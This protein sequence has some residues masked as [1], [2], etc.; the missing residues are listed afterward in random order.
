MSL[1]CI[2][3][4]DA[5]WD[6]AR[7]GIELTEEE[8][9]H[10]RSCGSCASTMAEAQASVAALGCIRPYP[11]VSDCR[12]A[13]M[14]RISTQRRRLLPV[15]S[16]AC[17]VLLVAVVIAGAFLRPHGERPAPVQAKMP[18]EIAGRPSPKML[19]PVPEPKPELRAEKPQ[20]PRHLRMR[21]LNFKRF[22]PTRH[23]HHVPHSNTLAQTARRN[24]PPQVSLPNHDS[25]ALAYVTWSIASRPQD[26]YRD[27]YTLTDSATGEITKC[28]VK[29]DGKAIEIN[30]ESEP[31]EPGT[32]PVP[33]K[34]SN[35]NEA[36]HCS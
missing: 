23:A 18:S 35:N 6:L 8:L 11:A 7:E 12:S 14:G 16:Y 28:S 33:V 26:F 29:R 36:I 13:V 9:H 34:E 5:I 30:M 15:W 32:E 10:A 21:E 31:A 25:R 20:A 3:V 17:A 22:E 24:P 2:S 4:S 27:S 1:D 19:I